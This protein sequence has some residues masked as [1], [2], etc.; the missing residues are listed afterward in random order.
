VILNPGLPW[1]QQCQ[2][3]GNSFHLQSV[4]K[5]KEEPSK[6]LRRDTP[7]VLTSQKCTYEHSHTALVFSFIHLFTA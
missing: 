3:E 5:F 7:L 1:K 2:Q 6:S 4:F